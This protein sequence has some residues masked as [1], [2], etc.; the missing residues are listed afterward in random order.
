[1]GINWSMK[2]CGIS[3][4]KLRVPFEGPCDI[5]VTILNSYE[6]NL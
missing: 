1:M 3:L 5:L 6:N 4:N 2:P